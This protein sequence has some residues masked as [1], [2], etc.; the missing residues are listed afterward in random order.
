[1]SKI[2]VQLYIVS[3]LCKLDR[4]RHTVWVCIRN[5]ASKWLYNAMKILKG[6]FKIHKSCK[7]LWWWV[8][9]FCKAENF[10]IRRS[11]LSIFVM[12]SCLWSHSNYVVSRFMKMDKASWTHSTRFVFNGVSLYKNDKTFWTYSTSCPNFHTEPWK[13]EKDIRWLISNYLYCVSRK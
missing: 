4:K 6:S 9:S 1:M 7:F 13:P 8:H 2:L 11:K 3:V 5:R 10:M 12:V